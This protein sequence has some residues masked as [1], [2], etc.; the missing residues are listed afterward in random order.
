LQRRRPLRLQAV[1]DLREAEAH[2]PRR[3]DD[4][5]RAALER[6]LEAVADARRRADAV[7]RYLLLRARLCIAA[8]AVNRERT[9]LLRRAHPR[10]LEVCRR[11][12]VDRFEPAALARAEPCPVVAGR[13]LG[14]AVEREGSARCVA[15]DFELVGI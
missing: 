9:H 5:A 4:G 11:R 14:A 8:L 6:E 10:L 15:L 1:L 7:G 12:A 3:Y 13:D 2:R